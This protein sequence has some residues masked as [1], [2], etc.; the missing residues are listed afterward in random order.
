MK[1]THVATLWGC[2]ST[3]AFLTLSAPALAS[4]FQLKEQSA[5]G[6]G[7]AFAG[8]TA[9]AQDLSTI[10]YNPAGM[11]RLSGSGAETVASLIVPGAEFSGSAVT[12]LGTPV[13]GGQGGDAGGP[14]V[15]PSF[16]AFYDASPDLKVGLAVNTPWGL[17]THYD[18]GWVGRYQA[19]KSDLKTI[20]I[21]PSAA[22]RVTP[23]LSLGAGIQIQYAK[24]HLTQ[25]VFTGTPQDGHLEIDGDDWGVGLNLG[26]LW[27]VSPATRV[28]LNWRTQ[29]E[30]TLAGETR[31]DLPVLGRVTQGGQADLTTPDVVSLG[32]YHDINDQ[33]AVMADVSWT[34]WSAFEE[35]RVRQDAG[36]DLV[37]PENW[38]NTM[39]YSAGVT[40][41]PTG[42]WSLQ[43]GI[44]YD[45][46]PIANES[47]RT[48]RIP[49]ADRLWLST[50]VGYQWSDALRANLAYTHIFVDSPSISHGSAA[51][52]RITGTYDN[53]VD[54]VA[55]SL[56]L[57]F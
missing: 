24:A 51:T 11:T 16:Y 55:A 21:A 5:E 29:V 14:A 35:L 1:N 46:T 2:A 15:V 45:T 18:D 12:P 23:A 50:G 53:R 31:L 8:S 56:S 36:P 7:N 44:A 41:R 37:T 17:K 34:R 38:D 25:S 42:Q 27:E 26:A 47:L 39:F 32:V 10:F 33:W 6:L 20:N 43:G 57:T 4:G 19:L 48:P 49:D 30:H 54:I 22:F 40:Y 52:G 3:L 9:K 28:G 13:A